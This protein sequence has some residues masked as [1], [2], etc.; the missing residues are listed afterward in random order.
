MTNP[1]KDWTETRADEHN[2]RVAES[3]WGKKKAKE[4]LGDFAKKVEAKHETRVRQSHK[5]PSKIH[6]DWGLVLKSLHSDGV[7]EESITLKLCNG[8]RYCPDWIIT[9]CTESYCLTA[10]EVK[11]FMRDDARKSLLFAAKEYPWIRFVLVWKQNGQW[12]QQEI[13]GE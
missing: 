9:T 13:L 12:Q 3:K 2:K 10:Y 11:G 4:I 5:E 1:F 8:V 6:R 7:H